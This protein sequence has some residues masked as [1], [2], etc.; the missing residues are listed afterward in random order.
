MKQWNKIM[1]PFEKDYSVH[2]GMLIKG[3]VV[4]RNDSAMNFSP[5]MYEEFIR[6]YDQRVFDAL[7]G[8]MI[9]FCGR[10]SHYVPGMTQMKNLYAINLTQPH[11]NDMDVIYANTI[12]KNIRIVNFD[13]AAARQAQKEGRRFNGKIHCMQPV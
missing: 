10:G 11:L 12:G 13:Y 9:H 8:G 1:P 7:G 2:W 4:L 6:P 3:Q 5:Q